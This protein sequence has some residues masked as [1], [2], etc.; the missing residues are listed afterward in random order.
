MIT[1]LPPLYSKDRDEMYKRIKYANPIIPN[2]F[3]HELKSLMQGLLI[4]DPNKRLGSKR[5]FEEIKE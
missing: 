3:S 2:Y 5:G 4:K 1:G